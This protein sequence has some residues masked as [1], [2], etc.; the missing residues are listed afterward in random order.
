MTRIDIDRIEQYLDAVPR[1]AADAVDIGPFTLFRP[2][3]ISTYYAR[4]RL[5]AATEV[6]AADIH[7]LAAR[8]DEFGLPLAIEATLEVT[9]SLVDA[10]RG[11][12][13]DVTVRPLLA[14]HK[15][16]HVPAPRPPWVRVI[17]AGDPDAVLAR[18]VAEVAFRSGGA[19]IGP[20]GTAER[21]AEAL[22]VTP[23]RIALTEQRSAARQTVIVGAYVD[24]HGIVSVGHHQP[25]NGCSEVV[26][27][28]TLPAFRR[29]GLAAAVTA[30]VLDDTFA[31]GADLV[32]L[33]AMNDDVARLYERLGFVRVAHAVAAERAA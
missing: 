33:S 7:D 21:D 12:G 11:A 15:A 13:L 18:A 2:T 25:V 26:G 31:G 5:G 28:S 3:T 6:T 30:A 22:L 9:P 23:E 20:E 29:R 4:P 17:A 32:I 8:C 14:L 16:D 27:V 1:S 24:G 19:A 10:A